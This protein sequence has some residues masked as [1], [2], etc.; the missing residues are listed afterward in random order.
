MLTSDPDS[1]LM[2]MALLFTLQNK[3]SIN[4]GHHKILGRAESPRA[5]EAECTEGTL[6]KSS[7]R[8][9]RQSARATESFSPSGRDADKVRGFLLA[10]M[11]SVKKLPQCSLTGNNTDFTCQTRY[12]S[13]L[14]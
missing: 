11:C 12:I 10:S 8:C 1:S 5:S 13:G 2:D 14:V 6:K 7:G 3:E 9:K 4:R